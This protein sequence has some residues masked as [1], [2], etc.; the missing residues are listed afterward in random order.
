MPFIKSPQQNSEPLNIYYEEIGS[1]K[2]VVF[3][4]GWPLSGSMW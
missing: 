3:I 1:G 2:T 4:H